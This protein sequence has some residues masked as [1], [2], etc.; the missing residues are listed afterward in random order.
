MGIRASG[1]GG[2][3]EIGRSS[4]AS[5]QFVHPRR[6][7]RG[8]E[9]TSVCAVNPIKF[10]YLCNLRS[11][12]VRLRCRD[13]IAAQKVFIYMLEPATCQYIVVLE[14]PLFCEALQKV[15]RFGLFPEGT[16]EQAKAD[17]ERKEETPK[18]SFE[19]SEE[20]EGAETATT[21]TKTKKMRLV[22]FDLSNP[23]L[24][25]VIKNK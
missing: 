21:T 9:C 6:H 3:A 10:P 25:V 20:E 17:D 11:C 22:Q 23:V 7:L 24:N 14:S 16:F 2:R 5:H 1:E 15:D 13:D 12:E 18:S 8:N 4:D 19:N